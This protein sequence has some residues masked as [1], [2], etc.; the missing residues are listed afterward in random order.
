MAACQKALARKCS[1]FFFPE[2][3]RSRTGELKP[4]KPGAFILAHQM[5]LPI[6]A[7]AIDGTRNALPKHSLNFHG[8]HAIRVEVLEEIPYGQFARLSV[9]ETAEMVRQKIARHLSTA[10]A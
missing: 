8:R 3:T 6:L 7:V 1:V 2:G 10:S 5:K 9:E 4:F